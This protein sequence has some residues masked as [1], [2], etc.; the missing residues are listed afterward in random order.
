MTIFWRSYQDCHHDVDRWQ[1]HLP[2][3]SAI[4]GVPRS[5]VHVAA[6]LA[7]IRHVPLVP[8]DHLLGRLE[9]PARPRMARNLHHP[10]GKILLV[11]DTSWGGYQ[12]R[13][14]A[15]QL[16]DT[17]ERAALYGS[18]K[19]IR[20]GAIHRAGYLIPCRH[21]T[22]A[23]NCFRDAITA[24]L[25]TDLD[26]VLAEDYAGPDE[27]RQP[28]KYLHWM[29]TARCLLRPLGPVQAIVTARVAKYRPQTEEWLR[30]HKIDYHE[31]WMRPSYQV[32]V[33]AWKAG[34]YRQLSRRVS[35]YVE[36]EDGLARA[37]SNRTRYP[38]ISWKAQ[39]C[40]RSKAAQGLF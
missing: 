5:G 1:R 9:R 35:C 39:T 2:D 27:I 12:M 20:Q 21:H 26:G 23:W 33:A 8:L 34:I 13:Y 40:F 30:A 36:S 6:M 29:Q 38:V 28:D 15:G 32:P 31:L 24:T 17:V 11:D 10:P 7:Q 22:F 37:I 4:C 16:P 25:A 3:Y 18:Q 14:L 19:A